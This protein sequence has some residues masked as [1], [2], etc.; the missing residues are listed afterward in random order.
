MHMINRLIIWSN[1]V[2]KVT[3]VWSHSCLSV[4]N[5]KL[6]ISSVIKNVSTADVHASANSSSRCESTF[7]LSIYAFRC[8]YALIRIVL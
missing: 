8:V 6:A 2:V 3:K 1:P 5:E 4:Y 7:K